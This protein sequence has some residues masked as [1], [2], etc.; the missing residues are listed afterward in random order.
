MTYSRHDLQQ[1]AAS[2]LLCACGSLLVMTQ[3]SAVGPS[4]G[5][6]KHKFA[7]GGL[8]LLPRQAVKVNSLG[9][10]KTA[11]QMVGLSALLAFREGHLLLGSHPAS[12]RA[13]SPRPPLMHPLIATPCAAAPSVP[14]HSCEHSTFALWSACPAVLTESQWAAGNR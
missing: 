3:S 5:G 6:R 8:C 10:W 1:T 12:A 9:K 7:D 4:K 13:Q 11:C 14:F 2:K